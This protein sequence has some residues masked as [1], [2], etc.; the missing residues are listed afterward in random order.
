MPIGCECTQVTFRLKPQLS[1]LAAL[2]AAASRSRP[3]EVAYSHL[4]LPLDSPRIGPRY[5]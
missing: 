2:D 4:P 1:A 3:L 5:A